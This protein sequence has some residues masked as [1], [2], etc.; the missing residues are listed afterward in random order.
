MYLLND[1]IRTRVAGRDIDLF[2]R[3]TGTDFDAELG[4]ASV[5]VCTL[6]VGKAMATLRIGTTCM[7]LPELPNFLV[8]NEA[9]LAVSQW[10]Q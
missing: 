5:R 6:P 7:Q 3:V 4:D 8:A 2:Q 10:Q 9:V 1:D